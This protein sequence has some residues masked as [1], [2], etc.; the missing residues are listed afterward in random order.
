VSQRADPPSEAGF[1]LVILSNH[2]FAKRW[3]NYELNG[4]L[5]KE[6]LGKKV[7]LPIWH[8]ISKDEVI[9]YSCGF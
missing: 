8:N 3:T 9:S 4:L 5:S 2:F 7:I 1:G 6:M